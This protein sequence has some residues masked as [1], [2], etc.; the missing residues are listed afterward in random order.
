MAENDLNK[1]DSSGDNENSENKV[2]DNRIHKTIYDIVNEKE[3]KLK[4]EKEEAD[5][6]YG[7]NFRPSHRNEK[8]DLMFFSSYPSNVEG[9]TYYVIDG[10]KFINYLFIRAV[11]KNII[12][13]NVDFSK[14]MFENS[15]L[16]YCKF[17]RCN[18][19]GAKFSS[20]NLSGSYFVDC[21]FDYVTF[22]KTFVDDEI[23][24]CAPKKDNLKYKFARSLKL[25]YVSIGDHIRASKAVTIELQATKAHLKDSWLSGEE[26][27]RLKY[28]GLKRRAEQFWKWFKV[29]ALDFVW[30]NGES[31][32][33]LIRFNLIIFILL[34]IYDILEKSLTNALDIFYVLS[35]K[36]PSN[37]F[38]ITIK[39][40]NDIN[41]FGYYPEWLSLILVITRSICFG[42][43]MSI[44]IK[45]YN[46]R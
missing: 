39:E 27:Y 41:Y 32:W 6:Q 33:R 24:E 20:S 18:F 21:N 3:I 4:R 10:R 31:L 34:S 25:N 8:K 29:S 42:L 14:T 38:G 35:I 46:R 26:W 16:R 37:Y 13:K 7:K 45:K 17:I 19:E 22:E 30:G 1:D 44:I 5:A 40:V 23:F 2:D 11:A 36:I 15:Y 9:V 12:F 28:G 43:L